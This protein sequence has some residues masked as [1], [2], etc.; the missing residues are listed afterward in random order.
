MRVDAN[1]VRIAIK[2]HLQSRS[3]ICCA[4]LG[5][6]AVGRVI[7]RRRE[8]HSLKAHTRLTRI[9]HA[10]SKLVDIIVIFVQVS[11]VYVLLQLLPHIRLT[12]D[13]QA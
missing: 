1:R 3:S 10:P 12:A 13:L 11:L 6:G 8:A 4:V 2:P 9:L 5:C 7:N